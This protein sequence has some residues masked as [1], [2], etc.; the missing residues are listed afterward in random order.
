M[1]A[2]IFSLS[3]QNVDDRVLHSQRSVFE[4]FGYKLAQ[5]R[6]HGFGHGQ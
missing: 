1:N 5:H 3:W 6:I 2:A 4:H